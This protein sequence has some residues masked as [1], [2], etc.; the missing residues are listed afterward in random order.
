MTQKSM[1]DLVALSHMRRIAQFDQWS[2]AKDERDEVRLEAG[3][4]AAEMFKPGTG[5]DQGTTKGD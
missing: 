3:T 5:A 1:T 4:F 2:K